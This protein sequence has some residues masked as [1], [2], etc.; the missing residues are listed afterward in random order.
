MTYSVAKSIF[1]NTVTLMVT[2]LITWVSG[3]LLLLF[4][5]RYLGSVGYG[6]LYVAMS[7]E[8]ILQW[9][10]DYGGQTY[11]PKEVARDRKDASNI[12][13]NSINL[14]IGLWLITIVIAL[15]WCFIA[16]YQKSIII[17]VMILAISNL[18]TNIS[19]LF[20][21]CFQGF[22][23]MKYPSIGA[24]AER[25]FLMLTAVPLLILGARGIVVVL[26]MALSK[27]LSFAINGSYV[28]KLIQV[29][30]SIRIQAIWQIL[31][32]S[33]P[34]FLSSLFGIIYYR[35]DGVMLSVMAPESIVGSYGAAY[36]LFDILMFL[37]SIYSAT[38]FPI[39]SRLSK[40][41]AGSMVKTS[42]KSLEF[43]LLAGIPIAV[44]IL[45]F[46]EPVIS[47][48]YGLPEFSSSVIVV[49]IFSVGMLLVYADF[50]LGSTVMAVDK[51][52]HW[53][54]I[55]FA[56][57]FVNI[58]LNYFLIPYFQSTSGNGGIGASI[59]TDLTELFMMVSAIVLV[60][61]ALFSGRLFRVITTGLTGGL[62]MSLVIYASRLIGLPW[63]G[64]ALLAI[65]AYLLCLILF[66][67]LEPGELEF[68][69]KT[70]SIRNL[71]QIMTERTDVGA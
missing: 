20:R 48:L 1:K 51:Q 9:I 22:E 19:W 35:I 64:Q 67:A 43:I 33:L 44:C 27:F 5:P 7:I 45:F 41:E 60:P 39:L 61:K 57:I 59:A 71:R 49:Q 6:E 31:K 10:I 21:G 17:L 12:I 38:L 54:A 56:A 3:F 70:F 8:M 65:P 37:P 55:A 30:L 24:I 63:I 66:K 4:L 32:Q 47:I 14:R 13:S 50:V 52:K 46:A 28:R 36:R 69:V 15:I 2:Q 40:T 34:Y 29:N 68:I 62:F 16:H 25:T 11:I 58:G 18:W 42:T 53:A 23:E 26:L